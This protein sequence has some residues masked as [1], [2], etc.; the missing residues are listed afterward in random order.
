[1][2]SYSTVPLP[3]SEPNQPE[4]MCLA[5]GIPLVRRDGEQSW[6]FKKRKTC[7]AVCAAHYL[8]M[9]TR[10]P[11][12]PKA[13]VV[14]GTTFEKRAKEPFSEYKKRSTCSTHCRNTKT[15]ATRRD[16]A[17]PEKENY[18]ER[19]VREQQKPC[20]RCGTVLPFEA[21]TIN[22]W[23]DD[24]MEQDCRDCRSEKRK[25]YYKQDPE[26]YRAYTQ[27][28]R[29]QQS[30]QTLE[31]VD[32]QRV[33]DRDGNACY[34]CGVSMNEDEIILDHVIPLSRGG[35]HCEDNLRVCCKRC[36][37]RKCAR[38]LEELGDIQQW[39]SMGR[40]KSKTC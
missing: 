35:P 12:P 38:L 3:P 22:I 11:S 23:F 32:R 10:Y 16:R 4:R 24:G 36:N 40:G 9:L 30:A 26:R 5:C 33:I 6:N 25:N 19:I 20:A 37:L 7:G 27:T 29:D 2:P 14:C 1:M 15:N 28:Y 31:D 8:S 34:L 17:R 21:F 39:V 13:C 18:L